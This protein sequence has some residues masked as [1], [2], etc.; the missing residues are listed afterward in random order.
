MSEVFITSPT[1]IV[2]SDSD[3][4]HMSI[5]HLNDHGNPM[6][7]L[8]RRTVVT[9]VTE[10]GTAGR[11][12]YEVISKARET[13]KNSY[14]L[15]NLVKEILQETNLFIHIHFVYDKLFNFHRK[16]VNFQSNSQTCLDLSTRCTN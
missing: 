12:I 16:E 3:F 7:Y 5:I 14:K 15:S 9:Y 6:K 1:V 10:I 4:L 11:N 8:W 13:T 2:L